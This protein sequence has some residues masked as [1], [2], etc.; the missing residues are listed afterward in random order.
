MYI[1]IGV[2]LK[3]LHAAQALISFLPVEN[4][5]LVRKD[6]NKAIYRLQFKEKNRTAV[7]R[8]L[9]GSVRSFTLYGIYKNEDFVQGRGMDEP[10]DAQDKWH[11]E[12]QDGGDEV[13]AMRMFGFQRVKESTK[14]V[15]EW[16]D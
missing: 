10:E 13:M 16:I 5:K 2:C 6:R 8:A 4:M 3:E 15:K 9:R 12:E 14:S 11:L 7:I 1:E